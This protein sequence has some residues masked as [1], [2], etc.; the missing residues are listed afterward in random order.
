MNLR[1]ALVLV[2]LIVALLAFSPP[3][4][5]ASPTISID[6]YRRCKF[7]VIV[8]VKVLNANAVAGGS[9][10]I[11]FNPSIINVQAVTSGQFD[12][13]TSNVD[14]AN[15][16]VHVAA[17]RVDAID[18][19]KAVLANISFVGVAE[20]STSLN[21]QN[22]SLNFEDGNMTIP[23]TADGSITVLNNDSAT[24][25]GATTEPGSS[26]ESPGDHDYAD[27]ATTGETETI[28]S[29]SSNANDAAP[30][31]ITIGSFTTYVNSNVS[32]PVELLNANDVA[33]GSVKITFNPLFVN[34]RE[35]V[36]VDFGTPIANINNSAGFV[37]IACA[38]P[39]AVGKETARL[40]NITFEG[41]SE[42]LSSLNIQDATFNDE[43]GNL[44][45]PETTSNGEIYVAARTHSP[46]HLP[47][48][49]STTLTIIALF[50]F[51]AIVI[52]MIY[53]IGKYKFKK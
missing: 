13:L 10:K 20:G 6:S 52:V 4:I 16:S 33:G 18:V 53:L 50:V 17:S 40:A 34:A 26:S 8:P 43:D 27:S 21:I 28:T 39:T 9:I 24:D 31:S 51:S 5:A 45:I 30:L 49:D 47:A 36:P 44:I 37:Y 2:P 1:I 12:T 15:G 25:T 3:A 46:P 29:T 48:A 35:V 38:S 7:N 32:V 41:L 14:N 42:G 22:A 23:E 19:E 11:S